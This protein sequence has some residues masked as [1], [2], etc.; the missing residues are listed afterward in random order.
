LPLQTTLAQQHLQHLCQ[1]RNSLAPLLHQRRPS[2]QP[3][4][5]LSQRLQRPQMRLAQQSFRRPSQRLPPRLS[6]RLQRPR[7]RL[8][9]QSFRR[10]SQRLP[11]RPSPRLQRPQM[12]LAQPSF[13]RLSRRLQPQ[14][15]R[16]AQQSFKRPSQ[17]LQ[18]QRMHLAEPSHQRQ[19]RVVEMAS[20]LPTELKMKSTVR[21]ACSISRRATVM[22]AATGIPKTVVCRVSTMP[23][24]PHLS[25]QWPRQSPACQHGPFLS[26]VCSPC[27]LSSPLLQCAPVAAQAPR[28][29]SIAGSLMSRTVSFC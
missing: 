26:F 4:P 25:R 10:P 16:L 18:R 2:R 29:R 19:S 27:S 5:R 15:M 23:R 9:Q 28:G 21:R 1:Q 11:P 12:R 6:R 24:R 7:V 20:A 13:R 22:F 3:L 14:R 8:A 17:R